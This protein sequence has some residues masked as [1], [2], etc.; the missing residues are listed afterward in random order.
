M[1]IIEELTQKYNLKPQSYLTSNIWKLKDDEFLDSAARHK[2]LQN[3]WKH[4]YGHG[5]Y[6]IDM[7]DRLPILF[8]DVVDEFLEWVNKNNPDFEIQQIKQKFVD[9]RIHL[10]NIDEKT[11]N[12]CWDLTDLLSD[13][14]I[15]Y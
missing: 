2:Q 6:G 9:I 4:K 7:T 10:G 12:Y 13:V 3:K 5:W 8:Y 15:M 1:T 11:G 14:N